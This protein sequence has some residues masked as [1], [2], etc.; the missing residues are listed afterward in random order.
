MLYFDVEADWEKFKKL[1]EEITK[2]EKQLGNL[3][4][5]VDAIETT[6][7]E[8]SLAKAR[9]EM[10]KMAGDAAIAGDNIE[11]GFQRSIATSNQLLQDYSAQ[12]IESKK[13]LREY[14]QMESENRALKTTAKNPYDA[15]V[16]LQN[17]QEA[18]KAAEAETKVV[19]ELTDKRE[20]LSVSMQRQRTD[21]DLLTKDQAKLTQTSQGI[22]SGI[23]K[24]AVAFG[25]AK[26]I[27]DFGQRIVETRAE[28]QAMEA[29]LNTLVGNDQAGVLMQQLK[30][31]AKQ[32]PLTMQNMIGAE[33]TM[34]S[35]GIDANKSV[36]Y[37]KAL[38]DISMGEAGKFNQLTLA[39]SQMSSA[40]KLMGQDLLQMINAG[41]NPL[42]QISR[43]T[44]KSIGQLKEEMGKGAISA[45]MVQKAFMDATEAGGKFAGMSAATAKTIG[46]QISMLND[47]LDNMFNELGKSA[48][49]FLVNGISKVT[50]LVE[51]YKDLAPVLEAT[52]ASLGALKVASVVNVKIMEQSAI[53]ARFYGKS[54]K[55]VTYS[56]KM[57]VAITKALTAAQKALNAAMKATP[58]L[59]AAAA[60]GTLVYKVIEYNRTQ[61][62]IHAG[63]ARMADA[64]A[65]TSE[66][67]NDEK[68]RMTTLKTELESLGEGTD[69]YK[70]KKEELVS[71]ASQY[72]QSLAKEIESTTDLKVC[73]EKLG[74]AIEDVNNKKMAT[75]FYKSEKNAIESTIESFVEEQKG[76]AIEKYAEKI[77]ADNSDEYV[78][79]IR[80]IN[81]AFSDMEASLRDGTISLENG[82]AERL[83]HSITQ[84]VLEMKQAGA[85]GNK[86]WNEVFK[87]LQ[88]IQVSEKAISSMNEQA[89]VDYTTIAK[90]QEGVLTQF[91]EDAKR[92]SQDVLKTFDKKTAEGYKTTATKAQT[93]IENVLKVLDETKK[94]AERAGDKTI[95]AQINAIIDS[96]KEKQTA[97][98]DYVSTITDR[99]AEIDNEGYKHALERTKKEYEDAKKKLEDIK[100]D[101]TGT[102]K[103]YKEAQS[104]YETK[105]KAYEGLGGKTSEK[106][107]DPIKK[108]IEDKKKE[109]DEATKL[110]NS[111]NED[112]AKYGQEL[113]DKLKASGEDYLAFLV[114]LRDDNK[115][116]S[117]EQTKALNIAIANESQKQE[118]K[119]S[120]DMVSRLQ[121]DYETYIE[122]KTALDKEYAEKK[123][124]YDA[125]GEIEKAQLLTED[126]QRQ[127]KEINE[128]Y[129]KN[130][131]KNVEPLNKAMEDASRQT[132][133]N[134]KES[135]NVLTKLVQYKKTNN[136]QDLEGS[137]VTKEQ[138]DKLDLE[139]L[140]LVYEQLIA[141]QEEY[142]EK[143]YYP[144]RNM[145]EGFKALKK[146]KEAYETEN[147]KIEGD[148]ETARGI[149]LIEKA[150]QNGV[151]ALQSL[152][153]ALSKLAEVSTNDKMKKMA[154]SLS[155]TSDLLSSVASGYASGGPWGA[156]IGG[157]SNI[158]TQI[159]N[160]AVEK[161]KKEADAKS[162]LIS[163]QAEYNKL[164]LERNYL[165]E[166]YQGVLGEDKLGRATAAFGAYKKA[167]E[168]YNNYVNK[169]NEDKGGEDAYHVLGFFNPLE[170]IFGNIESK[171]KGKAAGLMA[172]FG[173]FTAKTSNKEEVAQKAY[174]QGLN[175]LQAQLIQTKERKWFKIGSKDRY[176][177]LFDMAPEL[178]G[179]DVNGEFDLEAAQA[180][181]DTHND[182]DDTLRSMIEGAV[183]LKQAEEEALEVVKQEAS[184]IAGNM[185]STMADAIINGIEE[186]KDAWLDFQSAGSDVIK[187]LANQMVQQ[188]IYNNWMKKYEDQMVNLIGDGDTEGLIKLIGTIGEEM[189]AMYEAANTLAKAVYDKGERMGFSMYQ[190][191]SQQSATAGA[192]QTM[193]EDTA[194]VLEGRFTAVY[195]SNLAIQGA[196]MSVQEIVGGGVLPMLSA[197]QNIAFDTRDIIASSYLE[198][199][200]IREATQHISKMVDIMNVNIDDVRKN[201]AKL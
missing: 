200:A 93:E 132:K 168:D 28:F 133:K 176:E 113:Y 91:V 38:S 2:L 100:K 150:C 54:V 192:F 88:T 173:L 190:T 8:S 16:F 41:F 104:D 142:D 80:L 166:D 11:K 146:A 163:F 36:Q 182:I 122:A 51:S 27:K 45:E 181:L 90:D 175:N 58:W 63:E 131:L 57:R 12:L 62:E 72:D 48:E 33:K 147:G 188:L 111:T 118:A 29:A 108:L 105:K 179:G 137:G 136:A 15:K 154:E 65:K 139:E 194:G 120:K 187:N 183:S 26:V 201:T 13:R 195:E 162:A 79:R 112:T 129:G 198:Q 69:E 66:K 10:E 155:T 199:V 134:L 94:D 107:N 18:K 145:I 6:R 89:G 169:Q 24:L 157:A 185:T 143:S 68:I 152:S 140:K 35:F 9:K 30:G 197:Q 196:I 141:L 5:T 75:D 84:L 148:R 4:G 124:K 70:R 144:F 53:A 55:D 172:T 95:T 189:P 127:M 40:G 32:S 174:E 47:A 138:A 177:T 67:I 96:V 117:V 43:T 130:L 159:T 125:S 128:K 126:Y 74:R 99:L 46:G 21:Y 101:R 184:E 151:Q 82:F 64:M 165:E 160:D 17:E 109:Y 191:T 102:T 25:G 186:G 56:E 85:G 116:L 83:P 171:N 34:V 92:A 78:R 98:Q 135:L 19:Q 1:R 167:T 50:Q 114:K 59:L 180:F 193:S 106:D 103:E 61:K 77:K 178:W 42:E 73:Y 158:I 49:G 60:I 115:N 76:R 123:A 23:T 20:K 110:M 161:A 31:L 87:T 22:S 14:K 37:I 86:L 97:V 39:F 7:L 121:A 44:G 170:G 153:G 156:V 3:S 119:K 71:F 164:L 52:V 149:N 81:Q